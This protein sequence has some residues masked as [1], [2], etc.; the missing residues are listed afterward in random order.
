MIACVIA[1][2]RPRPRQAGAR[3]IVPSQPTGPF[4]VPTPVPTTSPSATATIGRPVGRVDASCSHSRRTPQS[5]DRIMS[6]ARSTSLGSIARI[7][8][9]TILFSIIRRWP[10]SPAPMSSTSPSSRACA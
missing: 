3:K 7:S 6:V 4:A 1:R 8:G 2:P 9:V 5:C 10:D